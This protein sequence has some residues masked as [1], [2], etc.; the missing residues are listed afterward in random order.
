MALSK[1]TALKPD[2]LLVDFQA[3]LTLTSHNTVE[4]LLKLDLNRLDPWLTNNLQASSLVNREDTVALQLNLQPNIATNPW[5][6]AVLQ[7]CPA[8]EDMAEVLNQPQLHNGVLLL[9]KVM[10]MALVVIR[11]KLYTAA[12]IY[13]LFWSNYFQV[14]F[15][16][17]SSYGLMGSRDI[18]FWW[19]NLIFACALVSYL[20]LGR[21]ALKLHRAL[22]FKIIFF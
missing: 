13:D 20:R 17:S 5:D 8:P 11:D 18:K 10:E 2:Q 4:C 19:H 16:L 12:R 1:A 9:H 15:A 21:A 14:Y 22:Y 7:H 3:H 6:T